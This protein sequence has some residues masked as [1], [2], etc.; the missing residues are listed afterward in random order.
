MKHL[1]AVN[2]VLVLWSQT[3]QTSEWVLKEATSGVRRQRMVHARLDSTLPPGEFAKY[4]ASDL[5]TW[6]GDGRDPEW[7]KILA[8][9]ASHVGTSGSVGTLDVPEPFENVTENHIALT[10]CSWRKAGPKADPKYPWQIHLMLV[11]EKES[12]DRVENVVYFFDPSY[13][14]NSP[15]FIDP[16]LN[17]Y[18]KVSTDRTNNFGVY[19]LA[20]GYSVVRAAVKIRGQAEIIN[21]SRLVD[22]VDQSTP[23]KELYLG[24]KSVEFRTPSKE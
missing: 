9:I 8:A 2:C 17:A 14:K 3:A 15:E 16:I 13:G 18:A 1:E 24:L 11:G 19:E 7:M 23:L 22:I 10:S 6:T 4:Q 21:L 5:S 20:N 12:L